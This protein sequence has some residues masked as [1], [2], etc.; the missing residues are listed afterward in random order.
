MLKSQLG[1]VS[2]PQGTVI[3]EMTQW[4]EPYLLREVRLRMLASVT[5]GNCRSGVRD[6]CGEGLW[7]TILGKGWVDSSREPWPPPA[8]S[9]AGSKS[10]E[11]AGGAEDV[12]DV[13]QSALI[14]CACP[15]TCWN[16]SVRA[17]WLGSACAGRRELRCW[18]LGG[19]W[20][21]SRCSRPPSLCSGILNWRSYVWE[22][23]EERNN[24]WLL[25]AQT[26][27]TKQLY[28]D[29]NGG[30]TAAIRRQW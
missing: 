7:A 30:E 24:V 17:C 8:S 27:I 1:A 21:P 14:C 6:L 20:T 18:C 15:W 4:D 19:V 2:H 16:C 11:W 22:T 12:V 3:A 25:H 13:I 10:D 26:A 29:N 23:T 9:L 28:I 5:T